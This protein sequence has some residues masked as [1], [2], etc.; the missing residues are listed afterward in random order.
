M[1]LITFFCALLS[2]SLVSADCK[3]CVASDSGRYACL[4]DNNG[5]QNARV[6][7]KFPFGAKVC[8]DDAAFPHISCSKECT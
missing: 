7:S 4:N 5:C 6:S 1:R 3:K 2:V 8:C